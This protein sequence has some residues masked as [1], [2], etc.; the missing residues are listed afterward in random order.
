MAIADVIRIAR[1]AAAALAMMRVHGELWP[2]AIF[3]SDDAVDI[4][5]PNGT[6][7]LRYAQYAAPERVLGKEAT[8]RSDV[9]SLGAILFHA[10]AGKPPFPGATPAEVMLAIC[11]ESALDLRLLRK[12]VS[13]EVARVFERCLARDPEERFASV[14]EMADALEK[15]TTREVWKGKRMLVA[16]DDAPVRDFYQQIA[17][18]IGVDIDVVA[19]GRDAVEA[20]KS[21]KYDLVLLDLNMPRLSGWEVLDFLRTR[22]ESRPRRLFI[23]TGFSDQLI[24]EADRELVTAVIYKP[25]AG[26]ELCSLITAS[27]RGGDVDVPRIL[28]KTS[29]REVPAY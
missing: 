21:R 2:S 12:D 10:L 13:A 3:V 28:R 1:Q 6:E 5:P 18:R 7:R 26:D 20:L 14:T 4:L 15:T 16:D 24:S 25:V 11:S 23:V 22:Y 27:L 8:P 19:T 17:S 9:F 29:H